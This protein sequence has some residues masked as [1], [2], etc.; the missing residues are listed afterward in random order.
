MLRD[1]AVY[2]LALMRAN[3]AAAFA[4]PVAALTMAAMMFANNLLFFITFIIYFA[5][6]PS[7]RGWAREDVA[8]LTGMVCWGFGLAI[9]L[10][11]GM[12][13]LGRLIAEGGLDVYL[14][15][16]R[17]PLPALLLSR[18]T[19]SGLGDMASAL[20]FWLALSGHHAVSLPLILLVATCGGITVAATI[21][22]FQCVVFWLPR[23]SMLAEELLQMFLTVAY[24]PQHIYGFTIRVMLLTVFPAGFV[25]LVPVA[26]VRDADPLLALACVAAALAYGAL[27]WF[28]FERGLRHYSSGSR[29]IEIR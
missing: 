24:Y 12:R 5:N 20:V 18:S 8:L 29:I 6:F 25:A 3:L 21:T 16:P 28:V 9:L 4:R 19:P 23:G 15:R 2:L 10:T 14:G 7:L 13:D 26:A 11:D 22:I 27:A 17:H 1:Q